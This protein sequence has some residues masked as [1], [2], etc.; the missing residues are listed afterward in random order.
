MSAVNNKI[1]QT[2]SINIS[3]FVISF[4]KNTIFI[5]FKRPLISLVFVKLKSGGFFGGAFNLMPWSA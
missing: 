3:C 4:F 1:I 2:I 5:D